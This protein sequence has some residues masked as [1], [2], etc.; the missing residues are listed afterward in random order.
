MHKHLYFTKTL[1][2]TFY[3]WDKYCAVREY[4]SISSRT[5]SDV[6]FIF[7]VPLPHSTHITHKYYVNIKPK[8]D[9]VDANCVSCMYIK[10]VFA[11]KSE[12]QRSYVNNVVYVV[13]VLAYTVY[14]MSF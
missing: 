7:V 6:Y 5:P 8:K 4:S 2:H 14:M 9:D 10:L 3:S 13:H 11:L 1:N 12:T